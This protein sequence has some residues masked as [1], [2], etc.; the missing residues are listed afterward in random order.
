[1]FQYNVNSDNRKRLEHFILVL[2]R[3]MGSVYRVR[4]LNTVIGGTTRND[5]IPHLAGVMWMGN[6]NDRVRA[7]LQRWKLL[8]QQYGNW[9]LIKDGFATGGNRNTTLTEAGKH[10]A[11]CRLAALRAAYPDD[12]GLAALRLDMSPEDLRN[13]LRCVDVVIQID[14]STV[15]DD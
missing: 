1:M 3:L 7:N 4:D 13:A 8:V 15:F 10:N 14:G 2:E 6:Y 5:V 9:F 11:D 12:P